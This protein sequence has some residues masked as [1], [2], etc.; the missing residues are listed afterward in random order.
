MTSSTAYKQ[1]VRF[2]RI[3]IEKSEIEPISGGCK[4][5]R[6]SSEFLSVLQTANKGNFVL[7]EGGLLLDPVNSEEMPDVADRLYAMLVDGSGLEESRDQTMEDICD[8]IIQEANLTQNPN[9]RTRFEVKCEVATNTEERFEFSHAFVNG[10]PQRLYQRVPLSKKKTVLRKTVHDSAWMFKK[11]IDA[12]I[13]Q[14][15]QGGVLVYAT[16][17]QKAE[18]AI[19]QALRVLGSV[20]RVLNLADEQLVR[21]EFE[22]LPAL[23]GH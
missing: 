23:A 9:F 11:V 15:G 7:V 14:A 16:E 20:T 5:A 18:P 17:E 21:A 3:E 13:I 1:W 2:W 8:R 6:S 19:D 12:G 4:V 22:G 10:S